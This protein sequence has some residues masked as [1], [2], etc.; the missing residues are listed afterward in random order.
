M[1]WLSFLTKLVSDAPHLAPAGVQLFSDVAHGKG[2]IHKVAQALAD[3]AG[4]AKEA[5][6]LVPSPIGAAIATGA[7]IVDTAAT[8]AAAATATQQ[9][10]Q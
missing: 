10:P 2:G 7:E 9:Q 6:A 1:D 8:A 4:V 5:A 3:L